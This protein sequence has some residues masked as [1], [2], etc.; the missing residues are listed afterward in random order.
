MQRSRLRR[1]RDDWRP[2]R[3]FKMRSVVVPPVPRAA[4]PSTFTVMNML[5]GYASIVMASDGNFTLAGWFIVG[6][7]VFDTI[8]GLVA[9]LTNSASEF[10]GELDSL[11]D[12]VSFGAAPSFLVYKFGL[13]SLGVWQGL[14]L[15]AVLLI[16]SGLRLARYNVQCVGGAKDFFNGLPTPSQALTVAA[17]VIWTHNEP[18]FFQAQRTGV[19]AGLTIC[20]AL[21]MVSA[22]QYERLPKPDAAF[23]K[24]HPVKAGVYITTILCT[25]CWG[26]KAFFLA[27]MLYLVYG[28]FRTLYFFYSEEPPPLRVPSAS[29]DGSGLE[30]SSALMTDDEAPLPV[31][32]ATK[33][34]NIKPE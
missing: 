3:K 12:L 20:L 4:V 30:M 13:L 34:Q 18:V 23:F 22:V 29:T 25:L 10:G 33:V 26:A 11:S 5:C 32:S 8:D 7:A 19:L 27:M 28:I 17:F 1:K 15:S 2:R 9:R 6:A 24:A 14:L 31:P 16:G 21:L